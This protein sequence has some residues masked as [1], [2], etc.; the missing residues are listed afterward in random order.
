MGNK[1]NSKFTGTTTVSSFLQLKTPRSSILS[2][3]QGKRYDPETFRDL[4][5]SA[6]TDSEDEGDDSKVCRFA[7]ILFQKKVDA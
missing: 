2:L 6:A 3:S 7:R 1:R 5:D 4:S